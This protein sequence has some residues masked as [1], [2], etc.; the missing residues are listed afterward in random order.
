MQI[1]LL[2]NHSKKSQH[3]FNPDRLLGVSGLGGWLIIVQFGLLTS[4]VG[5]FIQ[6]PEFYASVFD[7]EY[8]R[9]L[10][11]K[12]SELYHPL[13]GITIVFETLYNTFFIG[14]L[15]WSIFM[16]YRK[17][18]IVPRL[19]VILYSSQFISTI[20]DFVLIYQNP[21]AAQMDDGLLFMQL[22]RSLVS[23]AIWVPY[24]L[25]SKRVRNTFVR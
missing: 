8:W 25:K 13:W 24:F 23:F 12:S 3:T 21:I 22:F 19:L 2:P 10:T 20:I 17:K 4:L 5:L 7:S 15:I 1:N 9:A 18:S 11:S 6:M 16:F 14:L